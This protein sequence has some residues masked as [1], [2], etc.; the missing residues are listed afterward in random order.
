[1]LEVTDELSVRSHFVVGEIEP[2]ISVR[3]GTLIRSRTDMNEYMKRHD[4]VHFDPSNKAVSDRYEEGRQ[5]RAMR[6]QLWEG[7][8]RTFS[9][10]NKP[11]R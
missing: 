8:S 11:R 1:M 2:F 6:E 3:D 4:L 5:Q 7:V 10:G 9:M